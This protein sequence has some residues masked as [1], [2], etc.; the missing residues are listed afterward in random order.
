MSKTIK[1]LTIINIV[2]VAGAY[3]FCFWVEPDDISGACIECSG[4]GL[5][6][7]LGKMFLV[8]ELILMLMMYF[9]AKKLE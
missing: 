5:E 8:I 4:S 2:F 3:I 1:I 9:A 7:L 6:T